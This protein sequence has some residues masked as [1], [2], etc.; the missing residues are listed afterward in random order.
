MKKPVFV[1]KI[2]VWQP[3]PENPQEMPK[4]SYVD[5]MFKRRLSQISRMTIEVVHDVLESAPNALLV[6]A[7]VRGELS[8]Q[9]KIN[10]GLVEDFEISPAQFSISVFNTP[11]AVATIALGMKAGYTAVYPASG[12]FRDALIAA[13]VPILSGHSE[14]V[15]FAYSDEYIPDEYAE[16][17]EK[18]AGVSDR[19]AFSFA[20]VLSDKGKALSELKGFDFSSPKAFAEKFKKLLL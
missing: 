4:L 5:A 14:K 18:N 7:S 12:K 16:I 2:S 9:L 15:I 8:R 3:S 20:C 19:N 11:P 1:E 17:F 13:S 10:K 6:F